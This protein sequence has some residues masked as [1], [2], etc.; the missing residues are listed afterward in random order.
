MRPS[1]LVVALLAACSRES[2]QLG[3]SLV[4]A[5]SPPT[6]E[7]PAPPSP[8]EPVACPIAAGYRGRVLGLPVFARLA[9]EGASLSGR[10]FYEHKGIDLGLQGSL[11]DD[12]TL[13]LVEGD[14]AAPTGR[15]AGRCEPVTGAFAGTWLGA[16]SRGEFRWAPIPAGE[17]PVVAVKRFAVARPARSR[18]ADLRITECSYSESH[19]ELFGL[20]DDRVERALNRQGVEPLLGPVVDPALARA[21]QSCTD[22]FVAERGEH[23]VG[24]FRELATIEGDGWIDGG[25]AHPSELDLRRFTVDLRTGRR[26]VASDVLVPGRDPLGRVADCAAKA[27]AFDA[28]MDADEWRNHLGLSQIDL[29]E[30]G[31][32]FFVDGFPHVMAVLSGQGPV[33]G[34][35]VLLRD[36]YLRRDSPV[37]RA[38]RDVDGAPKSK[39]WCPDM[40]VDAGWR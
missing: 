4:A 20:R 2:H 12:G 16:R 24:T 32:H 21:V 6:T 28:S 36:G 38:W 3:V 1:W 10:Y 25:G 37:K 5:S 23:L 40:S 9:R 34:Y 14:A 11:S 22:G 30:D 26:V 27:T 29:A 8:P 19:L 35:D 13:H 18:G 39:P 15:F 31:V 7:T 17:T 33:I